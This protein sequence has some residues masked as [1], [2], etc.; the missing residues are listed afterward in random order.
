[1]VDTPPT[2]WW[3]KP[4]K[5]LVLHEFDATHCDVVCSVLS[6]AAKSPMHLSRTGEL[7]SKVRAY[8]GLPGRNL[9]CL[10]AALHHVPTSS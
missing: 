8:Y 1:M 6:A 9:N 7:R 4:G 3:G 2:D 5:Y 10:A